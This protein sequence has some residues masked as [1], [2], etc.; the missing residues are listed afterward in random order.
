MSLDLIS[1]SGARGSTAPDRR[2]IYEWA[3]DYVNLVGSY[4]KPGKFEISYSPYLIPIFDALQNHRVREVV[5]RKCVRGGGTM[6]FDVWL[7]WVIVNDPGPLS[8]I[9]ATDDLAKRNAERKNLPTLKANK[10]IAPI[11]PS[12]MDRNKLRTQ[13]IIFNNGMVMALDGS[14]LSN[15]Q[16]IS[17]RYIVT[18]ESWMKEFKP[19]T[20]DELEA[21]TGDFKKLGIH[22]ALH[23]SQAGP[24]GDDFDMRYM[25][26][27]QQELHAPCQGCGEPM[28]LSVFGRHEDGKRYG[29]M[30]GYGNAEHSGPDEYRLPNGNWN[31]KK[32]IKTVRYECKHCG[33]AHKGDA[34]MSY[35]RNK[36]FYVSAN[37][38]ADTRY[39][40][41][42]FS[43][44]ITYSLQDLCELWLAAMDSKRAGNIAP[45]ISFIQKYCAEPTDERKITEDEITLQIGQYDV[46][47]DWAEEKARYMTVDVQK[48]HF[49]VLIMAWSGT[50]CRRLWA[51]KCSTEGELIDLIRDWKIKPFYGGLDIRYSREESYSK[52]LCVKLSFFGLVGEAVQSFSIYEPIPGTTRQ[53]RILRSYTDYDEA[54]PEYGQGPNKGKM[55][56]YFLWAH[57]AIKPTALHWLENGKFIVNVGALSPEM[58]REF[59]TQMSSERPVRVWD[60]K[61]N[62]YSDEWQCPSRNN[63]L[64][65]CYCMQFAMAISSEILDD[66]ATLPAEPEPELQS[67]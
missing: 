29:L 67:A 47:S 64:W 21:R 60:K 4:I 16:Q 55:A 26:G 39:A 11:M 19:G 1:Q 52:K 46:Q 10:L 44:L 43:G 24:P 45:M 34:L 17:L 53:R 63:H 33:H 59:K 50:E 15:L 13:E 36:S 54:D 12:G 56:N 51:G 20:M 38:D 2:P 35:F 62:R 25:R 28:R 48:D 37:K 14:G 41:F 18:D 9:T 27:N 23:I 7:Q 65:D 5:I 58:E 66:P 61:R 30:W 6:V 40:S 49:W 31:I 42:W 32:A 22:K 3:G 57:L 8:Y